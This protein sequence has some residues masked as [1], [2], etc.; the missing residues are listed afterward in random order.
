MG[1]I[2]LSTQDEIAGYEIS[3]TLGVVVGGCAVRRH[4][5]MRRE[6]LSFL[7][8]MVFGGEQVEV[9]EM[10][11]GAREAARERMLAQAEAL[12]AEAVVAVNYEVAAELPRKVV[13]INVSGTAV[14]L[15]KL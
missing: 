3:E 9:T 7:R 2:V 5:N 6:L 10:L 14:K 8:T 15:R 1:N 4:H 12:A 11:S 13:E